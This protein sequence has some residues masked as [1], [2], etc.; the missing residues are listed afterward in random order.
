MF[1]HVIFIVVKNFTKISNFHRTFGF[2]VYINI[3][4]LYLVIFVSVGC[5]SF[6][7][8]GLPLC[9]IDSS[10]P[11]DIHASFFIYFLFGLIYFT[12]NVLSKDVNVLYGSLGQVFLHNR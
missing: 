5:F 6:L 4:D 11:A 7:M 10:S 9:R 12:E 1:F 2:V 3:Y 8:K